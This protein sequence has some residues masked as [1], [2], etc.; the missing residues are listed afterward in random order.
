[1]RVLLLGGEGFIGRNIMDSL[2]QRFECVSTARRPSP[3]RENLDNYVK[4]DVYKDGISKLFDVY[5]H[6]ID[7]KIDMNQELRL[8]EQ[9]GGGHVILF[10]SAVVYANP[11]SAY[12]R[13]KLALEGIYEKHCRNLTVL[14]LFNVYGKYQMPSS[15]G[16]LVASI[17][18]NHINGIPTQINDM[19]VER[20]FMFAG[21]VG[22]RLESIIEDR[23]TGSHDLATGKMHSL[24][25]LCR[26]VEGVVSGK[27]KITELG[28]ADVRCPP[29]EKMIPCNG[30]YIPLESGLKMTL[31][32][33]KK[34]NDLMKKLL[35]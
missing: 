22:R 9:M 1:M 16:G 24:R 27:L 5:I 18:H 25:E 3:F 10:S 7:A 20:D 30:N 19:D 17:L 8:L 11:T 13:R 15:P 34:N 4:K 28:T 6:L 2:S 23:P 32:F 35:S 31:D 14:R 29:A 12:G 26:I 33:F 21:D